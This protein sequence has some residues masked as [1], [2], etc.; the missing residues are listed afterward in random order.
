MAK[1]SAR[2]GKGMPGFGGSKG[3]TSRVWEGGEFL[4]KL[5]E[6]TE[7]DRLN[8]DG[9]LIGKNV[10]IQ[11]TC[12]DGPAQ[13]DD[14]EPKGK[15]MNFFINVNYDLP[16]TI[17]QVKDMFIAA[18]VTTSGDVPPYSKLSGKKVTARLFARESQGRT[19]QGI[20]FVKPAKSKLASR[21]DDDE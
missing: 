14:T 4:L 16:F 6:V 21:D 20:R 15:K 8:D 7:K 1:Q 13:E 12:L 3:S 19:Y 9:D 2:V 18:G 11:A 10:R 5:D 17:D